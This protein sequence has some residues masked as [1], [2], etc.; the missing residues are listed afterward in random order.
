[1]P[2]KT[3]DYSNFQLDWWDSAGIGAESVKLQMDIL[4]DSTFGVGGISSI[5]KN[6]LAAAALRQYD[7]QQAMKAAGAASIRAASYADLPNSALFKDALASRIAYK[8][9]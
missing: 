3:I 1:M 6:A 9:G 8:L 5:Q 2:E 4:I 7:S